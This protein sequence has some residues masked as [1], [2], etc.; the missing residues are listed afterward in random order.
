MFSAV[1]R[2]LAARYLRGQRPGG[3]TG[4]GLLSVI[5]LFSLLGV[6]L[7]VGTLVVVMAVMG[8]FST[9]LLSRIVAVNGQLSIDA[10]P[11]GTFYDPAEEVSSDLPPLSPGRQ[12]EQGILAQDGIIAVLPYLEGGALVA[13]GDNASGGFIRAIPPEKL[14]QK[15]AITQNI[16]AGSLDD[17]G[18]FT[19]A[20]GARMAEKLQAK[21]G[22]SL[23][24]LSTDPGDRQDNPDPSVETV[25][26]V[27]IFDVG[28]Y[29]F[30]S[31]VALLPLETGQTFFRRPGQVSSF[32]II[33]DDRW[34][35][36]TADD[37][38]IN[39]IWTQ[40]P[41]GYQLRDWRQAGAGFFRLVR[42]QQNAMFL[43]LSLIVMVAALNIISGQ[44]MLV[45]SKAKNIA[46]LRAGG[47]TK[48][49]VLRV[50]FMVGAAIGLTGTL[51]GLAG[52]WLFAFY[53]DDIR[54][55]LEAL[56]GINLFDAEVRGLTKIP[57]IVTWQ[58]AG[59]VAGMALGLSFIAS[60]YPAWKAARRDPVEGLRYG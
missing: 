22:D 54:L 25:T 29:D 19:I 3:A 57:A 28:L 49:F 48:G 32:E 36:D 45:S 47:A 33:G 39:S 13:N 30:D 43:I 18:G 42:T 5:T 52:G 8:G 14:R 55:W 35:G 51:A 21:I 40:L 38:L 59:A 11:G 46:T 6:M 4:R 2:Q 60:L 20:I 23:I 24:L 12:V 27:A 31:R 58:N 26:L 50:F 34:S 44:I 1:E 41:P 37:E 53:I 7:G 17:F 16:T 9:E 10:P 56:L 15:Q